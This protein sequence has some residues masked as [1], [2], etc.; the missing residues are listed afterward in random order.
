MLNNPDIIYIIESLW[1]IP[2]A[3]I[4]HE[5]VASSEI[6]CDLYIVPEV[7]HHEQAALHGQMERVCELF[8]R[9]DP[10]RTRPGCTPDKCSG[11]YGTSIFCVASC[12]R[13]SAIRQGE[14]WYR[15]KEKDG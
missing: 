12:K 15:Q 4:L 1:I 5:R 7:E 8:F 3:G 11:S 13:C 2:Q 6:F 10:L 9:S 14:V